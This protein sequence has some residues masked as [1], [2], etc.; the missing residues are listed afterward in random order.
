VLSGWFLFEKEKMDTGSPEVLFPKTTR[1]ANLKPTSA[2]IVILAVL[3]AI[4]LGII[5][6][7]PP[8][9]E[10]GKTGRD[11]LIYEG[12]VKRIHD[13]EGYYEAAGSELR[14]LGLPT[15]SAF[16]WRL[17]SLAWLMGHLPSI[18][19]SHFIA[20]IL[21]AITLGIWI[22]LLRD[23]SLTQRL[24]ASVLLLGPLIHALLSLVFL[25]HEF[26][27]GTLI[28]LSV[29]AYA[30]G[31]RMLSLAS[32]V[33][34]LYLRELALPFVCIMAITSYLE[35][36]RRE[37]LFWVLGIIGFGVFLTIH[38]IIIH[39]LITQT[40]LIYKE[41]WIVFGGWPFVLNTVQMHPFL[42]LAPSWVSAVILPLSLLGLIGWN[43]PLGFRLASIVTVYVLAFLFV[44][45]WFNIYWGIIYVNLLPLGFLYVP[46]S[47]RD[48]F[49]S[50]R[51]G[52][53]KTT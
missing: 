17:P 8:L 16:N 3:A 43:G 11:F 51:R 49:S 31:W 41:G 27:A 52:F 33:L 44:G 10:R 46:Y 25:L 9:P 50:F 14:S 12:I 2:V 32:G 20:I 53:Q 7:S 13:G 34:A 45:K 29:V 48:L 39:G 28:A 36:R 1:F 18:S 47:L 38:S 6:P 23:L 21:S 37:T 22:S 30:R 4:G 24:F 40:D 19:M 42:I 26:W 5:F 15:K 35:G